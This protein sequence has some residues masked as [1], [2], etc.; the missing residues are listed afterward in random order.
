MH[1]WRCHVRV[2][3]LFSFFPT[4]NSLLREG[5]S[6]AFFFFLRLIPCYLREILTLFS[7]FFL[8]LIPCYLRDILHL[9]IGFFLLRFSF[10][11][12]YTKC[13]YDIRLFCFRNLIMCVCH[14]YVHVHVY[15]YS[16]QA[17]VALTCLGEQ[18]CVILNQVRSP[19]VTLC[20]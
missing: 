18:T 1:Q 16:R 13:E 15:V 19:E 10:M 8:R 9:N 20:G 3:S 12:Y 7:L 6:E 17:G 2:C 14:S 5:D 4:L 11:C